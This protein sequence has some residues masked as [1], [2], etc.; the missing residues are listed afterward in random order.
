[1]QGIGRR[2]Y[3]TIS[4]PWSGVTQLVDPIS[5]TCPPGKHLFYYDQ[6]NPKCIDCERGTFYDNS[7][8]SCVGCPDNKTTTGPGAAG[9]EYCISK[10]HYI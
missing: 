5:V 4:L 2:R 8:M 10:D 9:I 7:T 3:L 1:M 6:G